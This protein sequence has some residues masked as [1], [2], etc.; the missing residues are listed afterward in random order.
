MFLWRRYQEYVLQVLRMIF[1]QLYKF[2]KLENIVY[3][4]DYGT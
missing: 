2:K 4:T 1:K 3:N